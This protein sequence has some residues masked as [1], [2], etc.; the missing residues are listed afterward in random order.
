[1]KCYKFH[2]NPLKLLNFLRM[3]VFFLCAH[4]NFKGIARKVASFK[5]SIKNSLKKNNEFSTEKINDAI[6]S[7]FALQVHPIRYPLLRLE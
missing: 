1:M 5:K 4:T 6:W 7:L 3:I 2:K